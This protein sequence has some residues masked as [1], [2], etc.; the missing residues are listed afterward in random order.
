MKLAVGPSD[1]SASVA[2]LVGGAGWGDGYLAQGLSWVKAIQSAAGGAPGVQVARLPPQTTAMPAVVEQLGRASLT[3]QLS[4]AVLDQRFGGLR[5]HSLVVVTHGLEVDGDS[6]GKGSQGVM[7]YNRV[8]G[9]SPLDVMLWTDHLDLMT[10]RARPSG[11]PED[12][13]VVPSPAVAQIEPTEDGKRMQ[14]QVRELAQLVNALRQSPYSRIYLAACGGERRLEH[15]AH[16][17]AA[18]TLKSIYFNLATISFPEPPTPPSAAVGPLHGDNVEVVMGTRFFRDPENP[19][20]RIA[21]QSGVDDFLPGSQGV[22][23]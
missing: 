8:Q 5:G 4:S 22:V 18:L 16:K 10:T 13:D 21:L 17:L 19:A 3:A 9:E 1:T 7:L 23:P 15:F 12:A 11:L 14:Q 6:P 20:N 2:F